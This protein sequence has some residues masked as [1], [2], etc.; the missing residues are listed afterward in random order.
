MLPRIRLAAILVILNATFA[1]A[2]GPKDNQPDAVRR[3]PKPGIEVPLADREILE[4][5]LNNLEAAI[6]KLKGSRDAWTLELIPDVQIYQR[7]VH[8]AL[9]YEEFF[10]VKEI[11]KAKELLKEGQKRAEQL[12]RKQAPWAAQT[13][14]VVRGYVSKI[15]GSVQ[16]YG[17]VVP[18]SKRGNERPEHR[19]DVWFGGRNETLSEVNF[20][21]LHSHQAGQFTPAD[22]I[23]LHPYGR[24]CNAFKFA[25]EV[26]VLEALE[27]V[28]QRY[29]VDEDRISVRGFSMGG[30][31]AWQFAVHYPDRWFAAN[32]GAGFSETPRFLKVFQQES[33]A[34]TSYEKT[35]WHLYDCTDYAAN[36]IACPTVAYSGELDSQKQAADVM[37]EALKEE[38]IELVHII[39]PQTKHAY[40]PDAKRE[41][42][43][44]MES[45]AARGRQ[46]VPSEV[47]LVAYTLKYNRMHWLSIDGLGEHWKRARVHA[48]L[49]DQAVA[50]KTE[51]VDSLTLEFPP[52]WAPFRITSPVEVTIDGAR[53]DGGRP[54]SDRSWVCRLERKGDG[55]KVGS[56]SDQ[57]LRKRHDLQGPIDD[58]FMDSF[59]FVL[60]TGKGG[61]PRFNEWA[62][63][64]AAHAIEHWRRQFRGEPRVKNDVDVSEADIASANL[65]LWGDPTTNSVLTRIADRL[66]IPWTHEKIRAGDREFSS[67]NH[68][69]VLIAPNPLNAR[70]YVVLNSGFTYREY[71]YLN[72]AR[73]VPKLP[74][75]AV[76]NLETP[77]NSRTPGSV[78][79]ADFFNERWELKGP[80]SPAR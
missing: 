13:G 28:K 26:D 62:G 10:D 58:A 65:V 61:N 11:A 6:E 19:L 63:Q 36:L 5:G 42:D 46:K 32:P 35:L 4:T 1:G 45:L 9:K 73:Q 17:L 44:R 53:L 75:W 55:W 49:G 14:L 20:L 22:T 40:H 52:G 68:G 69:L 43:R 8:D 24:Y 78:V 7:A 33:L 23:V 25:G 66:P 21:D 41:V 76:I 37:A 31:A 51:N 80:I 12:S 15:D 27:S 64:E 54:L 70:R 72:N 39:G 59:V 18:E 29:R 30:A 50:V 38:G 48:S 77:P 47:T 60:P 56:S 2:D 74:D 34:P 71:D 67:E 3:V 16:P 57:E 79:A